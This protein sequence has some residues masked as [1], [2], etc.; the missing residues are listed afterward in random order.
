MIAIVVLLVASVALIVLL[1]FL[2]GFR[3]GGHSWAEEA[4]R[5]RL[6]AARAQKELHDLTRAAF[7]AMAEQADQ[8][9]R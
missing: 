3:I 7:V 5:V 1:S 4:E 2:L 9:R 8:R 6:E